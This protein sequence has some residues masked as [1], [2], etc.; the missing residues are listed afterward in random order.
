MEGLAGSAEL[1][2]SI[3]QKRLQEYLQE[4]GVDYVVSWA[5]PDCSEDYVSWDLLIPDRAQSLSLPNCVKV[6][7]EDEIRCW[8]GNTGTVSLWS[9]NGSDF[10]R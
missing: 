1:A 2:E 9:F 7:Q 6:Y 4:M 5:G 8:S 10:V 3:Q